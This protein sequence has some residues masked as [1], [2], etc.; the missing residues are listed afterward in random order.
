M[1]YLLPIDPWIS[2]SRSKEEFTFIQMGSGHTVGQRWAFLSILRIWGNVKKYDTIFGRKKIVESYWENS[3]KHVVSLT[4]DTA[5]T[6]SRY[7]IGRIKDDA[8]MPPSHLWQRVAWKCSKK[9]MH[10]TDWWIDSDC[11]TTGKSWF[12]EYDYIFCSLDRER[13]LESRSY[14][15]CN[16]LQV[17]VSYLGQF[18]RGVTP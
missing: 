14:V 16:D 2:S 4:Y 9:I 1:L 17:K 12:K 15:S 5:P 11:I 8:T 3:W 7:F 6:T 10:I 13:L 18:W